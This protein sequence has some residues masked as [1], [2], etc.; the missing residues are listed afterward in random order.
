MRIFQLIFLFATVFASAG[1]GGGAVF[2]QGVPK[3]NSDLTVGSKGVDVQNLQKFLN[4]AGFVVAAAGRGSA[5]HETLLFG[6][7]TKAALA[8][9][10][11]A[12][13]LPATGYFGAKTRAYLNSIFK[14]NPSTPTKPSD[15]DSA[16][17][18]QIDALQQQLS[19]LLT[20]SQSQVAADTVAPNI[21]AIDISNG[22]NSLYIGGGD[23]IAITFSEPIDPKSVNSS[24]NAGGRVYGIPQNQT[25]GVNVTASGEVIV[26]GIADFSVGSVQS[27]GSFGVTL[28]LDSTGRVLTVTLASGNNI[29][30]TNQVVSSAD[31]IGG[32]IRDINGNIMQSQ[33]GRITPGGTF[34]GESDYSLISSINVSNG[35]KSGYVDDGDIIAIAFSAPIDPKS[36]SNNLNDGAS[37]TVP[38]DAQTG[39]VSVASNGLVTIGGITDFYLGVVNGSG[40]FGTQ[41]A[42][43]PT[44]KI[45]TITLVNGNDVR[46]TS[47]NFSPANQI[48]G[49]MK[50]EN[51]SV[52]GADSSIVTPTGTF[53]G[54]NIGS[55]SIPYISA[56][57]VTNGGKIG[58][59]DNGDAIV[60]T[61]NEAINPQSINSS[62]GD[63]V[64]VPNIL[65]TQTGGVNI[66]TSGNL[67]IGGIADF[68]VGSVGN[69]G[70]F[71]TRMSL[72][73]TGK[74]LTLLLTSGSDISVDYENFN[75][76]NQ[77]GGTV[78][79]N[80]GNVMSAVSSILT[81]G[82]TFGSQ[83]GSGGVPPYI[84]GITI[85]NG[86]ESGY[87]DDGDT[88]TVYFS[89][90]IN[91]KSVN[92]DLKPGDYVINVP[93]TQTGGIA[94]SSSGDVTI[95][96]IADFDMGAVANYGA[97]TVQLALDP[98]GKILTITLSDGNS[99]QITDETFAGAYQAGNTIRDI[100]GNKMPSQ[101]AVVVPSGTFGGKN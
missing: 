19:A 14:N 53:G 77:A 18:A 61:F 7:A 13:K 90:P 26:N 8:R 3:I 63:G 97:F 72:D 75:A 4:G 73:S 68:N 89:E 31:Q 20:Q 24:L 82:G 47:E 56:V 5:G 100:N 66:S 41:L 25:G 29:K 86:G 91:P 43:N 55:G 69:S 35:G 96:G 65:S 2:A 10:Q 92:S 27:L 23:S 1:F 34:G 78:R 40:S 62:L 58:Y 38:A 101:T 36:L 9:F 6:D 11:A 71:V 67:S 94:I 60:I 80:A 21:T 64:T 46:I 28:A 37:V 59:I 49:I 51:G 52:V 99:V 32:T 12:H 84:A 79:D 44:G 57:N 54:S 83:A 39:V 22:G 45:L 70:K 15:N 93:S 74:I 48:G 17:R 33:N 76:A 88:I 81:P 95:A 87:I 50:V 98:T 85:A 16:I 30:I 42:L